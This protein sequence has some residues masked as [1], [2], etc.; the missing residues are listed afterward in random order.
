MPAPKGRYPPARSTPVL[1]HTEPLRMSQ[2]W[3]RCPSGRRELLLRQ[4]TGGRATMQITIELPE[5]I[6]VGHRQFAGQ[7]G[8]PV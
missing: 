3:M 1:E 5:D 8:F 6:A 4:L 7:L 2:C